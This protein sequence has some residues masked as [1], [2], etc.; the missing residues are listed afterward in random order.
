MSLQERIEREYIAAYKAGDALRLS[1]LRL[2]KT[3]AK[4]LLVDLK[5]PGGTLSEAEF[6]SVLVKQAKQRRDS[7]EQFRA[8]SRP[9]L[10]GKEEAELGILQEYLPR[11]LSPEETR[12]AVEAAVAATGASSLKDMGRVMQKLAAEYAGRVDGQ[13][14]SALVRGRLAQ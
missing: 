14:L 10:A 4:N 3:A 13:S 7:I 9:D 5:R 2:L 6:V 11:P 12:A 8:A 1:V